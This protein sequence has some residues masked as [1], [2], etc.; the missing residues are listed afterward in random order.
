MSRFVPRHPIVKEEKR[1]Y[2]LKIKHMSKTSRYL[3]LKLFV[4]TPKILLSNLS[5]L[6][7]FFFL[8]DIFEINALTFW[9]FNILPMKK[10]NKKTTGTG[11][12]IL[13]SQVD[14]ESRYIILSGSQ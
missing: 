11:R 8:S 3:K 13:T 14:V 7:F 4:M 2:S 10:N 5:L 1:G 9:K 6:S 12:N